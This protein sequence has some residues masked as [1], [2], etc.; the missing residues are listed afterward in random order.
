V[1]VELPADTDPGA[2]A[3]AFHGFL[4][5]ISTQARDG[6]SEATLDAAV[7]RV[8]RLWGGLVIEGSPRTGGVIES[9]VVPVFPSDARRRSLERPAWCRVT[10]V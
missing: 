1:P 10:Y 8:I 3:T 2:L 7:M 4:M 5:G 9:D 6:V